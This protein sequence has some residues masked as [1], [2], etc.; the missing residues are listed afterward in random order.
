ML[1]HTRFSSYLNQSSITKNQLRIQLWFMPDDIFFQNFK[2]KRNQ[3]IFKTQ[4][5][6]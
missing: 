1:A 5:L 4:I 3:V 6:P 2:T